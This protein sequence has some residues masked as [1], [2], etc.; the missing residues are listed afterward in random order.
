MPE[1][2]DKPSQLP[3]HLVETYGETGHPTTH[4]TTDC[5]RLGRVVSVDECVA[6]PHCGGLVV[7]PEQSRP[8]VACA[9][10]PPG[11]RRGP[12][13]FAEARVGEAMTRDVICFRLDTPLD[14]VVRVLLERRISGAPVLD[15]GNR[16]VGVISKSDLLTRRPTDNVVADVLTH[17]VF[18]MPESATMMQAAA[19]MAFE[20]VHRTPIA[21][22]TGHVVGILS[23]ID[24]LRWMARRSGLLAP[25]S[26]DLAA[27]GGLPTD[28]TVPP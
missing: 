22:S 20:G 28:G 8:T 1:E 19:L 4:L 7:Q 26:S 10:M 14:E 15:S 16:I 3:V 23:A 6:C 2:H 5:P 18:V 12:A 24:V 9:P 27:A 13:S 25:E 11:E 17:L 21:S